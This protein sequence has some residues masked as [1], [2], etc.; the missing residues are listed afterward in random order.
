MI[1]IDID[2]SDDQILIN[3]NLSEDDLNNKNLI[4][5]DND[6]NKI[7]KYYSSKKD[8]LIYNKSN[9]SLD[10]LRTPVTSSIL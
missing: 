1:Y 7:R 4:I 8:V 6:I 9:S 2:N 10:T 3:R 5:I